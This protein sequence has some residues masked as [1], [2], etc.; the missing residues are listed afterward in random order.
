V[1]QVAEEGNGE[2]APTGTVAAQSWHPVG[3]SPKD[4]GWY[5]TRTNPNDQAYWDGQSWTAQRHWTAGKGWEETG[6]GAGPQPPRTSANPYVEQPAAQPR[7]ST[8]VARSAPS[9]FTLGLFLLMGGG[10][11]L[12]VGSVTTWVHTNVSFGTTFHVS[13]SINGTDPSVA[14]LI[15]INGY[16][17]LICGVVVI[18]LTAA[19]LASDEGSIR[20]LT[21]GAGLAALGFAIYDLVRILQKIN[22][23]SAHGSAG[24]GV[25]L[26]LVVVGAALAALIALGRMAQR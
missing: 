8:P 14:A 12:M 6:T 21:L 3:S 10:I 25:G 23:G 24:V 20:L 9:S 17:T 26:I 2:P 7:V 19:S 1:V 4:P 15:G 16:A 18:A 11:L 13:G 5:P 22:Q